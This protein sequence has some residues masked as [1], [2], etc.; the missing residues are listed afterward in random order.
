MTTCSLPLACLAFMA[1]ATAL[2]A[3]ATDLSID[4]STPAG[5]QG[6]VLAA[7]FDR[8]DGFPRGKPLQTATATLVDGKAL[9]QFTGLHDGDY[10]VSAFLD[11]NA[12]MKLDA[13]LFGL[14]TEPY[15]FSRDARAL[16]GPPAF[17][18]AAIR[19]DASTARQTI[20]LK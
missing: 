7:V 14:P 10:A 9:V 6:A 1:S 18:D 2:N 4:V 11:E 13:N 17:A 19:L 3:H 15:G 20:T 16:A 8:A 12:N 5:R